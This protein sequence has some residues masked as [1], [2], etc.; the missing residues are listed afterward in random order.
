[1]KE[2]FKNDIFTPE[3]LTGF[4]KVVIDEMLNIG[5]NGKLSSDADWYEIREKWMLTGNPLYCMANKLMD[6]EILD[7]KK[8][9]SK[10][11]RGTAIIKEELFKVLHVYCLDNK[12]DPRANPDSVKDLIIL[13]DACGWETDAQRTFDGNERQRNL[14]NIFNCINTLKSG[15]LMLLKHFLGA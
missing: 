7:I 2:D 5:Q 6:P 13:V 4:L 10:G 14:G 11:S 3:N 12:M 8:S 9:G 1:M 15:I